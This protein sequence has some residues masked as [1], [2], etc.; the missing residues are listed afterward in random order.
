MQLHEKKVT[1]KQSWSSRRCA[2]LARD[3]L[4][5]TSF[6]RKTLL[7]CLTF[8]IVNVAY[9]QMALKITRMKKI[10]WNSYYGKWSDWPAEWTSY[11]VG[12]EPILTLYRLD[13]DG[14]LF[15]VYMKIGDQEFSF[16]FAYEKY[17]A[18]KN[19]YQYTDG[20]GNEIAV[21]GSTLSKLSLYGWP[22]STVEIYF[23]VSYDSAFAL[24]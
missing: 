20:K 18:D 16:D 3:L 23:W 17:D 15:K 4:K 21:Q 22:D 5:N 1:A 7:L 11:E 19:W 13:T 2:G 8:L 9:S 24:E 6:I 10:S 14:Y 12:R